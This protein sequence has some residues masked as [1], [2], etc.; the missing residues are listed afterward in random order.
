MKT[1]RQKKQIQSSVQSSVE[2]IFLIQQK[3]P[4]SA[5]V[6]YQGTQKSVVAVE[7]ISEEGYGEENCC[8][9]LSQNESQEPSFN[10]SKEISVAGSG[11]W[12]PALHCDFS[13]N[14]SMEKL[15]MKL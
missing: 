5:A 4:C 13:C 11:S 7:S 2:Y 1:E 9:I 12:I 14:P 8:C 3:L 10:I 6:L 15:T